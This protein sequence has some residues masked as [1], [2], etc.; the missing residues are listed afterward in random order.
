MESDENDVEARLRRIVSLLL[1]WSGHL[2]LEPFD[3]LSGETPH[4]QMKMKN[5]V[6]PCVS[7]QTGFTPVIGVRPL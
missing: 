6:T 2:G 3:D 5:L 7:E 1:H 4:C